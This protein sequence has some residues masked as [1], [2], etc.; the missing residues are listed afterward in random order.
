M[1]ETL[2]SSIEIYGPDPRLKYHNSAFPKMFRLDEAWLKGEPNINEVI[3]ALRENRRIPEQAYFTA[4]KRENIEQFTS[5]TEPREGLVHL[6]DG[7]AL[8][9]IITPYPFGGLMVISE[10]VTDRLTLEASFNTLNA[11]QRAT[12]D[13]LYE[14][15]AVFGG[16]GRLRLFNPV[17]ARLWNLSESLLDTLPTSPRS[18]TPAANFSTTARTGRPTAPTSS[19][20]RSTIR[21]RPSASRGATARCSTSPRYPCPTVRR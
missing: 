21:A 11:A 13:N 16:D 17:Y 14:G 1:L 12:L 4:F 18:S 9:E 2:G 6:P 20:A 19:P 7:T 15:V 3:D 8:R 5:L 10:Y